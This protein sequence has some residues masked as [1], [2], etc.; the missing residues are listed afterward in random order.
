MNS[1]CGNFVCCA[2]GCV[3]SIGTSIDPVGLLFSEIRA[4]K[5]AIVDYKIFYSKLYELELRLMLSE[6]ARNSFLV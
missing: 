4:I 1:I 2:P 6:I 3:L 5:Q